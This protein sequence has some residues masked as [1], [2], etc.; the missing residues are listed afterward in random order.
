MTVF[1]TPVPFLSLLPGPFQNLTAQ[2][3]SR[4]TS[5]AELG[6]SEINFKSS[7]MEKYII[8]DPVTPESFNISGIGLS[9]QPGIVT[10]YRLFSN[11]NIDLESPIC[12]EDGSDKKLLTI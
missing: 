1:K 6:L 11:L 10:K 2:D 7:C 5:K 8:P 12:L 4:D 3:N 9:V